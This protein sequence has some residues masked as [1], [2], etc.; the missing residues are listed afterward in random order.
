MNEAESVARATRLAPRLAE[1]AT[2]TVQARKMLPENVSLLQEA[3]LFRILQPARWGG[4]EASLHRHLDVVETVASACG[5]TGWCLGVMHAH[6][7]LI[8]LFEESAQRDVYGPDPDARISA[9]LAPRGKARRTADGYVLSG[10]W[11]FCSGC[12]HAQ[13][14][15]F[16]ATVTDDS[17]RAV[18]EAVF[19]LPGE[20]AAI[21]D[22]WYTGGLAGTGSNS[23]VVKDVVVPAH[24]VLSMPG[25]R[26][27]RAPGAGLHRT[28]LYHSA[29][30]PALALFL[31]GP[32][33]GIARRA[34][35]AFIQRLPGRVVSYTFGEKQIEMPVTHLEVAEAATKLDAARLVLHAVV[36]EMET[37]ANRREVMPIERRAKARMDCAYAVRL[38]MEATDMLYLASGGAGLTESSTIQLA[39]RDLHAINMHGMLAMKT[40]L[41]TYGR[42]LLG[43]APNTSVL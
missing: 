9:V 41:E 33:L 16:G 6:S 19:L 17:G 29:A 13:W 15:I 7:W 40:N 31:C 23:V 34:L 11:P 12:H 14:L 42:A 43:L 24:R 3:G 32:A 2:E 30:V 39:T 25:V 28:N 4:D 5:A 10:F 26:E 36:D 18:D 21:Q 20:Q 22:D 38:C 8:G 27:G 35:D 1:R 37:W